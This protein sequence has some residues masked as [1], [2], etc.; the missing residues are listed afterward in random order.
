MTIFLLDAFVALM[1]YHGYH[2]LH[3]CTS[4]VTDIKAGSSCA[5]RLLQHE[6]A[7]DR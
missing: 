1:R 5:L 3:A 2:T 6:T 4:L 7:P